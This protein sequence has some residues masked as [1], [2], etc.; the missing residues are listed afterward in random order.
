MSLCTNYTTTPYTGRHF[1]NFTRAYWRR[2]NSTGKWERLF[3]N[4]SCH[5]VKQSSSSVD[6]SRYSTF[7]DFCL[8]IKRIYEREEYSLELLVNP[9]IDYPSRTATFVLEISTGRVYCFVHTSTVGVHGCEYVHNN[10]HHY[11]SS[12]YYWLNV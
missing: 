4:D 3:V 9:D 8:L 1:P 7:D 12:C 11:Q 6:Y 5:G 2:K 10:Y